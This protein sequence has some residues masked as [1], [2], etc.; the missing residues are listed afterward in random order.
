M[1]GRRTEPRESSMTDTFG[2]M[3]I[4]GNAR[5]GRA[6]RQRRGTIFLRVAWAGVIGALP[7]MQAAPAAAAQEVYPRHVY[8][9]AETMSQELARFHLQ[10]LTGFTP[11]AVERPQE[12]RPRHVLQEARHVHAS[13][14]M[15][16]F[17]HGLP[18]RSL[19]P[20]PV[21][22][23]EPRDVRARMEAALADLRELRPIYG[24]GE[25]STI[26]PLRQEIGPTDVFVRLQ[27]VQA[28]LRALGL[29]EIVPNDAYRMALLVAEE[30]EAVA[31]WLGLEMSR[32]PADVS[33]K[34]PDDVYALSADV[35]RRLRR[36][37]D[38]LPDVEIAGGI[39]PPRDPPR[40]VRPRHVLFLM[41]T[42]LAELNALKAAAGL[43]D[44][45]ST[46]PEQVGQ[47]PSDVFGVMRSVGS[48][49]AR[50]ERRLDRG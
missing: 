46:P 21:R 49:L 31:N 11:P 34:R 8:R 25:S 15:L 32:R 17:L 48:T 14:Q 30:T 16:R 12:R 42:L 6:G 23:I 5:G 38:R 18:R 13:V 36:V 24:L 20:V 22:R 37:V 35:L 39:L 28:S 45:A 7:G 43:A 10:D 2:M 29:P 19:P 1:Q 41:R 47:T 3:D 50:I 9:V 26:A 33:D 44:V 27:S 40:K 4:F